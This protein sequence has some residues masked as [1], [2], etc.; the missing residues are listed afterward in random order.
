MP[1]SVA[2]VVAFETPYFHAHPGAHGCASMGLPYNGR[3][4]NCVLIA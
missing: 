2:T 3:A 4:P 1:S